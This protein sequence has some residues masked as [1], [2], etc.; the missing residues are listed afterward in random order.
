M[1]SPSPLRRDLL[2]SFGVIFAEAILILGV[3]LLFVIPQAETPAEVTFFVLVLM[4][5]DLVLFLAY[6]GWYLR[7][8]FVRPVERLVE[9]VQRIARGDYQHRVSPSRALELAQIGESVNAMADRLILDKAMLADNVASLEAT[10]RELVEARN[11]VIQAARLASVGTLAAGIAHEVGN[12]LGAIVGYVD[13]ARGRL[14]RAGQDTEL[15]D[16]IREEAQ[17]IDRIV[18]GLLDYSRPQPVAEEPGDPAEVVRQVRD[19]LESQGKLARV[20]DEWIVEGTPSRVVMDRHRLEQVLVNLVLNAVDALGDEGGRL[21]VKLFEQDGPGARFPARREG[22]PPDVNYLHRRRVSMDDQAERV[23]T[24]RTA[25]R[26]VCI[27]VEDTGPGI[28]PGH[29]D[30]LFDPFFTTKEPGKGTGLGLFIC[31]RL[32]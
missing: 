14:E 26:L 27:T 9:D 31:A 28:D 15:L 21:V 8:H 32:V 19:L 24:L 10:N 3:A 29:I 6:G 2:V 4:G 17:R 18:R 7:R 1:A 20:D 16:A 25:E 22:D 13:V 11:Q 12:P 30:H 23:A 5:V